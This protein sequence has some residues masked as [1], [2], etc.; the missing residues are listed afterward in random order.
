M[1][2]NIALFEK[3]S[4]ASLFVGVLSVALNW[5][6]LIADDGLGLSF[7]LTLS[8]ATFAFLGLLVWLAARRKK[9]EARWVLAIVLVGGILLDFPQMPEFMRAN[10]AVASLIIVET[11]L[12]LAALYF[13][14]SGNAQAYFRK[15]E[16][17]T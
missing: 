2:S 7:T 5:P 10:T 1:P 11:M 13:V 16:A 12:Q 6:R 9:N 3:L 14:F 17:K 4:Y 15:Q 8:I